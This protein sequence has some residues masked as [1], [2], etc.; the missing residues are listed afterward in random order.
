MFTRETGGTAQNRSFLP[1]RK[2][3]EMLIKSLPLWV[4]ITSLD[5]RRLGRSRNFLNCC[6]PQ[7]LALAKPSHAHSESERNVSWYGH[8][9]NTLNSSF[10]C[11]NPSFGLSEDI[12]EWERTKKKSPNRI[13]KTY[14]R[15][16]VS[17]HQVNEKKPWAVLSFC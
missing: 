4:N 17:L 13:F 11:L 6:R 12:P 15:G 1:F 16:L 14:Q 8:E 7:L 2:L 3:F 10:I 9:R 5:G